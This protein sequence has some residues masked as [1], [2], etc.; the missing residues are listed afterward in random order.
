AQRPHQETEA[1]EEGKEASP[2]E[3]ARV[4][5]GRGLRG[6]LLRCPRP[7]RTSRPPSRRWWPIRRH[8]QEA[9]PLPQGPGQSYPRAVRNAQEILQPHRDEDKKKDA[10]DKGG[11]DE[12]PPVENVFCIFGGATTN[13]ISRQRKSERQ[14]VFSVTKA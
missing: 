7:Q 12:F 13:M 10:G 4:G 1:G 14:E 9:V 2:T 8:A 6:G 11:D 3:P 5:A